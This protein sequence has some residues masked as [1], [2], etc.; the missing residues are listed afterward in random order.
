M[1]GAGRGISTM[2]R[3]PNGYEGPTAA[4]AA[5]RRAPFSSKVA[6][7]TIVYPGASA[8]SRNPSMRE[9]FPALTKD[10][11]CMTKVYS[12]SDPADA[13]LVVA[14]LDG[15]EGEALWSARG[16]LPLTPESAPSVWVAND[17]DAQRAREVIAT[18]LG[19]RQEGGPPWT[20][21]QCGELCE[22]QFTRCWKCG[23]QRDLSP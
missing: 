16:E 1:V 15:H 10:W 18:E 13:H 11:W 19:P 23:R 9:S 21:S 3:T 12:A 22:G 20:C 5:R 8:L 17:G 6:I 14:I 4:A 7:V 2:V